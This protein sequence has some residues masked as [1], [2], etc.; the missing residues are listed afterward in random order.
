MFD[1]FSTP[2]EQKSNRRASAV[3]LIYTFQ[4]ETDICFIGVCI[5]LIWEYIN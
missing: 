1:G 3:D 2:P 4:Q 5:Q